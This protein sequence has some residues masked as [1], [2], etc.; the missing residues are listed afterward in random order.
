MEKGATARM[1]ILFLSQIREASLRLSIPYLSFRDHQ[2]APESLMA[3][4]CL[5]Q[6]CTPSIGIAR[7]PRGRL[8]RRNRER[9]RIP[10]VFGLAMVDHE[11][12]FIVIMVQ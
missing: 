9:K 3:E 5:G 2:A 7:V 1:E 4:L 6:R 10:D 8:T 12:G 11:G